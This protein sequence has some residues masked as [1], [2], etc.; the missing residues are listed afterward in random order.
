MRLSYKYIKLVKGCNC[1]NNMHQHPY[2]FWASNL[3]S[4]HSL[5]CGCHATTQFPGP[6]KQHLVGLR[7]LH[8]SFCHRATHK[9]DAFSLGH[10]KVDVDVSCAR[11]WIQYRTL[12]KGDVIY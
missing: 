8:R 12:K 7:P 11:K 2:L 4:F 10:L 5:G 9:V 3:A 1:I 6:V